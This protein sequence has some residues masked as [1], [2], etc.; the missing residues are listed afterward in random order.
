MINALTL[1]R[2]SV[3]PLGLLVCLAVL[4]PVL[5]RQQLVVGTIVN[6]S[7]II[8]SLGFGLAGGLLVGVLPSTISLLGG[9]L[10][11][12]LMPMI[13]FIITGNAMMALAVSSLGR[14]NYWAGMVVGATVKFALLYA[15]SAFILTA[16]LHRAIPTSI[17][18]MMAWP[19]LLTAVLGGAVAFAVERQIHPRGL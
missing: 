9:L 6:A 7:I 5:F 16:V 18:A 8:A 4:A 12:P 15:A 19:Q 13:P 14:R 1:K 17:T 10:P 3:L 2:E 11:A